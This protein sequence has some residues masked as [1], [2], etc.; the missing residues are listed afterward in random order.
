MVEGQ[1]GLLGLMFTSVP[2]WETESMSAER[3][4][5]LW[6]KAAMTGGLAGVV[7]IAGLILSVLF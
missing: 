7:I 1:G 6:H 2:R 4:Q 5:A 3:M